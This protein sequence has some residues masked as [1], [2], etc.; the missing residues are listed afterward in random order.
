MVRDELDDG[1][2]EEIRQ[3]EGLEEEFLTI[4]LARRFPN[5]LLEKLLATPPDP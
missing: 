2:L 5:P 4:T 3:L 1:L